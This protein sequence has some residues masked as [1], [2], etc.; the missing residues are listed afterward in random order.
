MYNEPVVSLCMVF[1]TGAGL[2][3]LYR[4]ADLIDGQFIPYTVNKDEPYEEYNIDNVYLWRDNGRNYNDGEI[5]IWEWYPDFDEEQRK[6]KQRSKQLSNSWVEVVKFP[7]VYDETSLFIHLNAGIKGYVGDHKMLFVYR[8]NDKEYSCVLVEPRNWK[9]SNGILTLN[10]NTF[11]LP[12]YMIL[13]SDVYEIDTYRMPNIH[14]CFYAN[15]L[16]ASDCRINVQGAYKTVYNIISQNIRQ[17]TEGFSK[18]QRQDIRNFIASIS[19]VIDTI[20]EKCLCNETEA[21]SIFKDF[22]DICESYF[23]KQEK[24]A[25]ADEKLTEAQHKFE[26]KQTEILQCDNVI[27]KKNIEIED[28]ESQI[29]T[30]QDKVYLAETELKEKESAIDALPNRMADKLNAARTD[31]AEFLA[32]FAIHS[33]TVQTTSVKNQVE[34]CVSD[35]LESEPEILDDSQVLI[36][37]L[38]DNLHAAGVDKQLSENL[39]KYLMHCYI[40]KI[41]LILAG[42][43]SI[44]I[45]DAM[46][47]TLCNRKASRIFCFGKDDISPLSNCDGIVAVYDALQGGVLTKMLA[48][49]ISA[50]VYYIVPT[51]E[52][53]CIEPVGL[54]DYMPPVFCS[55]FTKRQDSYEYYGSKHTGKAISDVEVTDPYALMLIKDMP[56]LMCTGDKEKLSNAINSAKIS[57]KGKETLLC[58]VGCDS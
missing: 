41:P 37:C 33:P 50:Y 6:W 28:I 39:A 7:N 51:Q 27:A 35:Y 20:Q 12:V 2:Q 19:K 14:K 47:A 49:N 25:E 9:N 24:F 42:F 21:K 1:T 40:K 11:T 23:V 3:W 48:T 4:I 13:A 55:W 22:L 15:E 17:F 53:L 57:D 58:L 36:E 52:E 10:E 16:R 54:F 34:V 26:N 30:L 46:S 32:E 45:A 31:M 18:S 8:E 38:M 5:G 43:G 44:P 29:L 56:L